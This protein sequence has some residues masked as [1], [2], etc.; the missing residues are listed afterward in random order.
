MERAPLPLWLFWSY[1]LYRFNSIRLNFM[2]SFRD[3]DDASLAQHKSCIFIGRFG[4]GKTS[5]FRAG[6]LTTTVPANGL[7]DGTIA[8]ERCDIR[9]QDNIISFFDTEGFKGR[10]DHD[11][12]ILRHI[13][14]TVGVK[15]F[16]LNCIFFVLCYRRFSPLDQNIL[17]LIRGK[18]TDEAIACLTIIVTHCPE[19][20]SDEAKRQVAARF[21][22]IPGIAGR[23]LTVDLVNPTSFKGP[24]S[25]AEIE[26][27][28]KDFRGLLRG[29]I[30]ATNS[31]VSIT[32]I[33]K[34]TSW[35]SW[36]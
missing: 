33:M 3:D 28:W 15:V 21:A 18:F 22:F 14:G 16:E 27:S 2:A 6:S 35:W 20:E 4:S 8:C 1:I 13:T 11:L 26:N 32:G 29:T 36:W 7:D 5:S 9:T 31:T 25:K 17:E 24:A 30:L 34:P 23:I 12:G 19:T 10:A